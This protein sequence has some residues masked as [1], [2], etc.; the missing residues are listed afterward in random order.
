MIK[1]SVEPKKLT[2]VTQKEVNLDVSRIL[3]SGELS[4]NI[5]VTPNFF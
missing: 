1:Y 3:C 4:N 2:R 5:K